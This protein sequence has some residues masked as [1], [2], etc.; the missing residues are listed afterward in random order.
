MHWTGIAAKRVFRKNTS[1]IAT[2]AINLAYGQRA[3]RTIAGPKRIRSSTGVAT[4]YV[5]FIFQRIKKA[6]GQQ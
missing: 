3:I 4:L 5:V 2:H 6:V 1:S